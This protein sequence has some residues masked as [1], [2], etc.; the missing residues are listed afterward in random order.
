MLCSGRRSSHLPR[1]KAKK[2]VSSSTFCL[3]KSSKRKDTSIIIRKGYVLKNIFQ[4]SDVDLYIDRT[5]V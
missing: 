3:F 2:S 5:N 4:K 1:I